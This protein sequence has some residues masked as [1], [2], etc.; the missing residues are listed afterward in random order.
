MQ[1]TAK[2]C[3][4]CI[5][6]AAALCCSCC[7]NCC[8]VLQ[9]LL[10]AS[11]AVLCRVDPRGAWRARPTAAAPLTGAAAATWFDIA[12]LCCASQC[13]S[14]LGLGG[15]HLQGWQPGLHGI[16]ALTACQVCLRVRGFCGCC[17]SCCSSADSPF[18]GDV[19]VMHCLLLCS[20]THLFGCVAGSE[21]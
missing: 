18:A 14:F 10:Y 20:V 15:R 19:W 4:Y 7:C 6:T 16:V 2:C 21:N 9:L 12:L 3:S 5:H 1:L 11:A 17:A 13:C 8:C